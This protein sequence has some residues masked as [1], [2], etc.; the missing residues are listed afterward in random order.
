MLLLEGALEITASLTCVTEN[1]DMRYCLAGG[2]VSSCEHF[3]RALHLSSTHV[4][5]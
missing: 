2:A 1:D 5:A 3:R 4:L